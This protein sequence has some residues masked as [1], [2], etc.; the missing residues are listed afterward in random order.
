M[1]YVWAGLVIV[2]IIGASVFCG[3]MTAKVGFNVAFGPVRASDIPA[4]LKNDMKATRTTRRVRFDLRDRTAVIPVDLIQ[5][6]RTTIKVLGFLFL[7][8]ILRLGRF[9]PENTTPYLLAV[10][11]GT[12][13]VPLILPMIPFRSFALKGFVAG[14]VLAALCYTTFRAA[15]SW[16]EITA[17][18]LLLPVVSSWFALNF[19]GSTTFTS[20]S[21]VNKELRTTM[22]LYVITAILVIA[23]LISEVFA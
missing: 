23:I 10:L 2:A 15:A 19:T 18:F 12:G 16:R 5:A 1:K 4:F 7:L 17:G 14:V 6:A 8:N 13:L 11:M 21:G 20:P 22:P 3:V 9:T